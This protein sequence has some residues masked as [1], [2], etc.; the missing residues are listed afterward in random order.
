MADKAWKQSKEYA[1]EYYKKNREW[2][3]SQAK[4]YYR[5][6]R[7]K[8][9]CG[10]KLRRL[11]KSQIISEQQRIYRRNNPLAVKSITL[12]KNYGIDLPHYEMILERQKGKCAICGK[13][14]EREKYLSVGHCHETGKI[15]GLLC[16]HCNHG[17]GSFRDDFRLLKNAIEYLNGGYY[18][19]EVLKGQGT[20]SGQLF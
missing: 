12:K 14:P 1:R 2:K 20:P 16:T 17:L 19:G 11:R 3:L 13:S 9:L 7:G 15:R 6:N 10:E 8:V 4:K 5:E 18:G